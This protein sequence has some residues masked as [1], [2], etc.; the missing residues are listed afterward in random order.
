MDI[1]CFSTSCPCRMWLTPF[2][3]C[4]CPHLALHT[5][6][7]SGSVIAGAVIAGSIQNKYSLPICNINWKI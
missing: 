5:A 6:L 2:P 4:G 3:G 7:W 1:T